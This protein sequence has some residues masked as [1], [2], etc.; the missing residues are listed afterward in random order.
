MV[1][2]EVRAQTAGTLSMP[3]QRDLPGTFVRQGATLAYV[4][5]KNE[6]G[7][8][9]AVPEYDA[10]LVRDA[11]RSVEVRLAGARTA[12]AASRAGEP[13]AAATSA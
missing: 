7:I 2:L 5:E 12:A 6:V 10:A 11:T 1:E 3:H 4:I 9:A 8:R 13:S